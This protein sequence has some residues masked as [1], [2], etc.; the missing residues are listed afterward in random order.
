MLARLESRILFVTPSEP[1]FVD[2][3]PAPDRWTDL[4]CV[5]TMHP[6]LTAFWF[7]CITTQLVLTTPLEDQCTNA[8]ALGR[9]KER[10]QTLNHFISSMSST[11]LFKADEASVLASKHLEIVVCR[12][13]GIAFVH[14]FKAAGTTGM[15]LVERNCPEPLDQYIHW[16]CANERR[17]HPQWR[18]HEQ[19]HDSTDVFAN[20]TTTFTFVR[21]PVD[22]FQS[23]V[24]E[25]ALRDVK[26]ARG[27][28]ESTLTKARQSSTTFADIVIDEV[29]AAWTARHHVDQ[30][31]IPQTYS[32]IHASA[33]IP[34]L[35]H[36]A[37]VGP[38]FAEE[39]AAL[40]RDIFQVELDTLNLM[41]QRD[42]HDATYGATLHDIRGERLAPSTIFKIFSMYQI[43]YAWLG[44]LR[45]QPYL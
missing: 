37:L 2:I 45:Y 9:V 5:Y 43:D 21:D 36:V 12:P 8:L 42:S 34:Q 19:P 1:L 22:R 44:Q 18:C 33:P 6:T 28:F 3:T 30:H 41:H 39:L 17:P 20:V 16:P 10:A 32:L 38:G 14:V 27:W 11:H 25:V 24:F 29:S 35:T 40:C 31:M 15:Q 23:S 13:R 4:A 26:F 7:S